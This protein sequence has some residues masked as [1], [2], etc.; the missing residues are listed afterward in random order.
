LNPA[1]VPLVAAA[2]CCV[3]AVAGCGLGPGEGAEGEVTLT[4]TRDFGAAMVLEATAADPAPSETVVRLLDREAEIETSYGG[5]F[6]DS[7]EG[8]GSGA[9]DGSREDWFFYVNG[10]WSPVGAGEA[11]L[12]PGDRIWWDRRAWEGAYR[13]PA[14]VGSWPEPFVHGFN[15]ERR[16]V[17]LDCRGGGRACEDTV[18]RLEAE[19]VEPH[20]L[21]EGAGPDPGRLRV[22]VGPWAAVR[23]DPAAAE[24]ERGP[25]ESGV[26]GVPSRCRGAWRLVVL[27]ADAEPRRSLDEAGFVAAVRSDDDEPVWVVSA[28]SADALG[29]AAEL[30]DEGTLRN[31]FAVAS[32]GGEPVPL[33]ADAAETR[34]EGDC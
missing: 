32:D 14:V 19:G 7:I 24:L 33:P 2:L 30:L 29:E 4:V 1:R 13:V 20:V 21:G 11:R 22:L 15:G 27:G 3:A 16:E 12:H 10:Y 5:N 34:I 26:Y 23:D 18:R 31:R 8:L 9:S 17:E 28:T 6:V 25:A